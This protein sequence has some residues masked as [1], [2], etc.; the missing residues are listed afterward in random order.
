MTDDWSR[1]VGH[2]RCRNCR[3]AVR[4][5]DRLLYGDNDDTLHRCRNCDT[6]TR[7]Q[8]G[9]GAG[10]DVD[11]PDPIEKPERYRGN[12][13]PPKAAILADGGETA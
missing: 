8:L 13:L 7:L 6:T 11:E 10:L 3:S 1:S 4:R 9:S 2:N 5:R 12:N